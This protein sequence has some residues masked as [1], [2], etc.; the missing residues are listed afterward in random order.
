MV[1]SFHSPALATL[2]MVEGHGVDGALNLP[3]L[4]THA[5]WYLAPQLGRVLKNAEDVIVQIT[6][7]LRKCTTDTFSATF[8]MCKF[9]LETFHIQ[10]LGCTLP[11]TSTQASVGAQPTRC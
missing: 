7:S 11:S 1:D 8:T 3:L 6:Y 10:A 9:E 5:G 4:V 2:P